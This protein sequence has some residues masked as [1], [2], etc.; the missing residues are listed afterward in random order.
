MRLYLVLTILFSSLTFSQTPKSTKAPGLIESLQ[1]IVKDTREKLRKEYQNL[2]TS[3][4]TELNPSLELVQSSEID[5]LFLKSIFL[6]SEKRYLEMINL[7]SCHLYALLENQLLKS[8]LGTVEFLVMVSKGQKFLIRYDQYVEQIYKFKCQQFAQYS[9]IFSRTNLK[10]TVMAIP[11]PV[12]KT[13]TQ[14]DR[15]IS[16]WKKNDYLPYLCK[17]PNAIDQGTRAKQIRSNKSN[18]T[19]A[20]KKLLSDLISDGDYYHNQ[21]PYFERSYLKNLCDSIEK[22]SLF[23]QPYLAQDAWSKIING[24]LPEDNLNFRCNSLLNKDPKN[25]L[26]QAQKMMCATKLAQEPDICTTKSTDQYSAIYPRANCSQVSMALNNGRLKTTFHD[27]PGQIDNGALT[28]LHRILGHFEDKTFSNNVESCKAETTNT[29]YEFLKT[30]K[31]N[32]LWPLNI[33]Y[34]DKIEN[35]ELCKPYI[36]GSLKSSSLSEDKVISSILQRMGKIRNRSYCKIITEDEYRPVLLE[37]KNGCFITFNQNN[38]SNSYC[39]KKIIIDQKEVEGLS[40]K[41]SLQFDYFPNNWSD[42]KRSI[43][44]TLEEIY[45]IPSKKIQNLTMLQVFLKQNP[46]G[47]I[48]GLGCAEDL[49]PSVRKRI[50]INQCTP[51]PFIIDGMFEKDENK[52]L[53]LRTAFDDILSPRLTPWNWVFTAVMKYQEM[54]PLKQWNLYGLTLSE[55][56]K[57]RNLPN[58]FVDN[59][60]DKSPQGEGNRNQN[61]DS[62]YIPVDR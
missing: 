57:Y 50:S 3:Q 2:K 10:K 44:T 8:A 60:N 49:L 46:K 61:T 27:C 21:I 59:D 4:K 1:S 24:E 23:C 16:D 20:Q 62:I 33:C 54:H 53:V 51:A 5:S 55:Q 48:H 39:P 6:H 37:Y 38:C 34:F 36:P 11:Y 45:K 32:D 28:N 9:K 7:N 14:C 25:K 13:E 31:R 52:T 18:L 41:G 12:P 40:F 17:I 43:S 56:A 29:Y 26:T 19:L 42:Q 35:K 22:K 47:I 30:A 15:I 58:N